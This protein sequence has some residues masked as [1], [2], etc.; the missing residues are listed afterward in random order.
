MCDIY[1]YAH[2]Q[3][4]RRYICTV[5]LSMVNLACLNT[6]AIVNNKFSM[7]TGE[8]MSLIRGNFISF[9]SKFGVCG[10]GWVEGCR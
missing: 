5:H 1:I 8:P 3:W 2:A 4:H 9:K 7:S 10:C 6:L